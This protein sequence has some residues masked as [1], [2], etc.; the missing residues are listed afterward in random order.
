MKSLQKLWPQV[1]DYILILLGT[2][3]QAVSLRLFLIPAELASGGVS[4]I[5]QLINHLTAHVG[6]NDGWPIGVMVLIG[7]IPLFL[8][9][10][11]FLGGRRFA[12]RTAVA[13]VSY[14]L[15]VDALL[16][17]PFFPKTGLTNDIVLNSLYGAVISG[18]GYGLVYRAR[19][20]SGGS[21]ILARILNHWRAIPMT[22]SYLMVDSAVILAAGFV[23]GWD[24]A[25]YA[26]IT[27]YVSG[28]VAETIL[29][30]GGTVRT[31][32]IVTTKP[33]EIADEILVEL[34]RGVTFL[35]GTGAYTGEE[36]PVLYCVVT[37]AEIAQVKAIVHEADPAAFMVIGVAH[38][39]LGEGFRPLKTQ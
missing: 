35:S 18:V 2:L 24:K 25:L 23:F 15:A 34:E 36:R 9:G 20:T 7:N 29:E 38:E 37:R 26:I 33:Q 3:I 5:A 32:M 12:V 13:I 39:A 31:A 21:D 1:G 16:F 28:L 6:K 14:S 30:G 4:G 10:W 27:L 22:Q 19:G 8:L 11:R 17:L